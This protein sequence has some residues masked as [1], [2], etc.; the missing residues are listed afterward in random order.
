MMYNSEIGWQFGGGRRD[1]EVLHNL[2]MDQYGA[3]DRKMMYNSEIS[4]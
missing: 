3:E 4:W 1:T 2:G